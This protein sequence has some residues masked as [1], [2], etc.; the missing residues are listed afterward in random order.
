MIDQNDILRLKVLVKEISNILGKSDTEQPEP[1]EPVEPAKP[2]TSVRIE[3]LGGDQVNVPFTFGQV[4]KPGDLQPTQ[5]LA[6]LQ[7]DMKALHPDG[8]VRH[9]IVSGVLPALAVGEIRTIDLRPGTAGGRDRPDKMAVLASVKLVVDSVAYRA[10]NSVILGEKSWLAGLVMSEYPSVGKLLDEKGNAHP[11]LHVRFAQRCYDQERTRVEVVIENNWAYEPGPRNFVYDVVIEVMGIQVLSK[12]NFTHYHHARWRSVFWVGGEPSIHIRHDPR[13][14]IDTRAIPNYDPTV[15]VPE[16]TIVDWGARWA[17]AGKGPMQVGLS[18]KAM[19]TT[20]GRADIGLLPAWSVLWLLTGDARMAEMSLG[21]AD[22]SGSWSM[23]YRDKE[24]GQPISLIDYPYMT[25]VGNR[26]DTGN[27]V[28][29]KAEAFPVMSKADSITPLTHDSAHQPSLAFL[30]Y[31]LTGE[32]YY[33]EELQFWAMLNVF[34]SNPGYREN[35]KGLLKSDQ[36]RGQAWGLRTVG[37]AAY[38]T[39]DSDRLKSHFLRVL[40]SNLDWYNQTYTDNPGANKLGVIDTPSAIVYRGGLA[41]APWQD[42]FVTQ[43]IGYLADLG[44]EKARR[45]L[46]WKARFV[47]QRMTGPEVDWRA[48]ANYTYAVRPDPKAELFD[49]IGRAYAATIAGITASSSPE[50]KETLKVIS[51]TAPTMSGYPANTD[52]YPS[53]MQ[54]ALAYAA[55]Y[56]GP[57][58][59]DAWAKFMSRSVKPNYGAGPQFAIVPRTV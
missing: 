29:K 9:A 37:H 13:Y 33:L 4:F 36:V 14:L 56:G 1:A 40:D 23:H 26:G 6:G 16:K 43:S 32:F 19:G 30:P 51:G 59:R 39:P 8:S 15:V 34:A 49:T 47:V 41:I 44:F 25:I 50:E 5:S 55:D 52:G 10:E 7:V 38:I 21:T 3:N 42:D 58:A 20:G 18:V 45:F 57:G 48:A 12:A 11:H 22:G 17:K 46:G 35:V 27:P 24:T 31:L 28:T 54:P 2:I 53:N